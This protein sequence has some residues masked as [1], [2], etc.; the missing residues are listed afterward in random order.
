MPA[1][2]IASPF[3]GNLQLLPD[4]G[5]LVGWGGVRIVTE[6]APSGRV[7]FQLK[8]GYGDSYRAYRSTW[9][10]RPST[11]PAAVVVGGAAYASWNGATG[12]A[13]WQA[14]NGA[15]KVV[16]SAAWSGLETRIPLAAGSPVT[17]VRALDAA[18]RLLGTA[19]LYRQ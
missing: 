1:K 4:G 11:P 2:K 17:A 3:E 12:I 10:G 9:I 8:L 19:P 13:R 7:R 6:F 5:A 18:G 16:G 15:G 14:V